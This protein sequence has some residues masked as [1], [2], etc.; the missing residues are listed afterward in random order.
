MRLP[1][2]LPA[3]KRIGR[4]PKR[5]PANAA[6]LVREL[7]AAGWGWVGIATR[8]ACDPKT[9]GK[10]RESDPALQEAFDQGREQEHFELYAVLRREANKGNVTAAL[11]ILNARHG[12]RTDQSDQSGRAN[13]T[14]N[15]PGSMTMQQFQAITAKGPTND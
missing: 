4:P 6:E 10:W 3:P 8:L 11:A 7:S 9:L 13:I 2:P 1:V 14:I 15:L 5:P 12:W